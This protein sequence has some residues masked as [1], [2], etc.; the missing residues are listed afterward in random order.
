MIF[1]DIPAATAVFLDANVFV[2]HFEPHAQY[3][4]ACT[5]LIERIEQQD[6][7]GW[8]SAHVLAEAAHRL[9]AL[10]AM[11]VFGWPQ[12]GIAVRLRN[13]PR[14]VQT[15]RQFRDALREI[16]N[17]GVQLVDLP[18]G[19]IDSAAAISQQT[20]LLTNDALIVALMHAHQLT[21][22]TSA[23]SDFDRAPG[24]SRYA[25]V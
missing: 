8:T 13:H 4:A 10:E 21:A 24:I 11:K 9:M 1:A 22:L 3:G 16:P 23:D 5:D 18:A 19:L 17:Y 15:L 14:E 2:Y 7:A 25:P 6:L 20:G 12:A